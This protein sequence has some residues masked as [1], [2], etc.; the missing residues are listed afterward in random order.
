MYCKCIGTFVYVCNC[1]VVC[2]CKDGVEEDI[3]A[4][5]GESELKVTNVM[6][7]NSLR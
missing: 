4:P 2:E 6:Y 5:L 7:T 3:G 1:Y